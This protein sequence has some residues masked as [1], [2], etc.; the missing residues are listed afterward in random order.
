[1][2]KAPN[3]GLLLLTLVLPLAA[4]LCGGRCWAIDIS[5]VGT[6]SIVDNAGSLASGAGSN[7][8][9][10][11]QSAV[12]QVALSIM[13]AV[14]GGDN[15][16]V[17]VRRSDIDWPVGLSLYVRRTTHGSGV[18]VINGGTVFQEVTVGDTALFWGA[19]NRTGISVQFQIDGA[20]VDIPPGTYSTSVI[21]TV[22][23]TI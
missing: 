10:S 7:L 15:W 6:W 12:D 21:F 14:D 5:G 2:R 23:D 9:S 19:S 22:V 1:M 20:S 13:N 17:D 16:R 4:V 11:R 8:V 18:G 3:S